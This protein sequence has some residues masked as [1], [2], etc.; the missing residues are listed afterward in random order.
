MLVK[1]LVISF[2]WKRLSEVKFL[3]IL[4]KSSRPLRFRHRIFF[5]RGTWLSSYRE[6]KNRLTS[7]LNFSFFFVDYFGDTWQDR[8][9]F[10]FFFFFS[11]CSRKHRWGRYCVW[12]LWA[13]KKFLEKK[14]WIV[15]RVFHPLKRKLPRDRT[16]GAEDKHRHLP[17]QETPHANHEFIRNRNGNRKRLCVHHDM[18]STPSLRLLFTLLD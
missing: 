7:F 18:V 4:L 2:L 14:K 15:F 5:S 16:T 8:G 12:I 10:F 6:L 9:A 3:G 1:I 13:E 17:V 11:S